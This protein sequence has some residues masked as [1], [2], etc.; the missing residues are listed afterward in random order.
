MQPRTDDRLICD[1]TDA[2]TGGFAVAVALDAGVFRFLAPGPR[3][4]EEL[5]AALGLGARPAEALLILCVAAGLLRCD[6]GVYALT[7]VAEDY[8]VES[9]PTYAGSL[10]DLWSGDGPPLSFRTL[11]DAVT[12][13]VEWPHGQRPW[14][15]AHRNDAARAAA[16][17]RMMHGH[18]MAP[19]LA[20]PRKVDLGG[21]R[22]LLDVGGG[23]GAHSIGALLHWPQLAATVMD[24]PSVCI[25]AEHYIAQYGM[26]RRIA[27]HPADMWKDTW[28]EA[29]IHFY[30]DIF[31]NWTPEE[32]RSLA[33]RSFERLPANGLIIVHEMLYDDD[34]RGPFTVAASSL[35]ML[36]WCGGQQF[37]GRE[38]S[39]LLRECG[40]ADVAVV[41][42]F[43]YWSIVT[44]RRP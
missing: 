43:G 2:A 41:P 38:L 33:R 9:S 22:H 15:E 29:D 25:A 28:P 8:L 39:A 20:W 18:S 32:C 37:S 5:C 34:K 17:T 11:R 6:G 21:R 13:G 24:L 16:F 23:S 26:T 30:A 44:G 31:H 1:L 35:A 4:A 19:A 42:T 14:I 27:T 7:A 10:F 36:A 3:T 40:F 12:G